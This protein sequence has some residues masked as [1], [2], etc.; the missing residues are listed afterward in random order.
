LKVALTEKQFCAQVE[1]GAVVA[2]CAKCS[3][4]AGPDGGLCAKCSVKPAA[5]VGGEGGMGVCPRAECNE[6]AKPGR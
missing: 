2:V 4:A 3:G 1:D 5:L 6:A